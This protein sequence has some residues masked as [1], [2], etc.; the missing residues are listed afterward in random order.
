MCCSQPH[1]L[2]LSLSICI[3]ALYYITGGLFNVDLSLLLGSA[4]SN[5]KLAGL[6]RWPH[7]LGSV[8][9]NPTLCLHSENNV[10]QALPKCTVALLCL[11]YICY[12]GHMATK[13]NEFRRFLR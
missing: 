9:H 8:M 5:P 6:A 12:C 1:M 4:C 2:S 7:A 11:S 3:N 10:K 13:E